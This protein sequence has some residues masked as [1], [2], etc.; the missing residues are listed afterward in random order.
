MKSQFIPIGKISIFI[1]YHVKYQNTPQASPRIKSE[2]FFTYYPRASWHLRGQSEKNN[3]E[4]FDFRFFIDP[5]SKIEKTYKLL[6][7]QFLAQ[8]QNRKKSS[9]ESCRSNFIE[10]FLD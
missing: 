10:E 7:I 6:F 1:T 8:E 9:S 4:N 2:N 5:E 3:D